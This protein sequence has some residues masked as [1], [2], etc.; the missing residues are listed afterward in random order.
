MN[1]ILQ[2]SFALAAMI[3]LVGWMPS[4]AAQYTFSASGIAKAGDVVL[5]AFLSRHPNPDFTTWY[6]MVLSERTPTPQDPF[7]EDAQDP[8]RFQVVDNFN[9]EPDAT[10]MQ[11]PFEAQSVDANVTFD[12]SGAQ[13]SRTV[14][15]RGHY[16]EYEITLTMELFGL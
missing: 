12:F 11:V 13:L 5:K 10:A 7:A 3:V 15:G 1:R 2:T 16:Q 14:W 4:G 9:L 8:V 6:T